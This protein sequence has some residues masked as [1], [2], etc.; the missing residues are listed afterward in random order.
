MRADT[1][2]NHPIRVDRASGLCACWSPTRW[3]GEGSTG[4]ANAERVK[5]AA[6]AGRSGY[7][8]VHD[9]K[10][11]ATSVEGAMA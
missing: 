3:L 8:L 9:L 6:E 7:L 1:V 11:V 10:E 4:M 5:D 2:P